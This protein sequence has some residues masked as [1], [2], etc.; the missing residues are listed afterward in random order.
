M[1]FV[2]FEDSTE[3]FK[4]IESLTTLFEINLVLIIH[5]NCGIIPLQL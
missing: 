5:V 3:I 4:Y 2:K 1:T